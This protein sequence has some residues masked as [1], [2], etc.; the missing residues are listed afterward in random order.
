M[1]EVGGVELEDEFVHVG[2]SYQFDEMIGVC[3]GKDTSPLQDDGD[4]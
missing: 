2:E 1:A 3:A 4:V